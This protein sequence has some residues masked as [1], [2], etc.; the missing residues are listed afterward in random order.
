M[1]HQFRW[2]YYLISRFCF[3]NQNYLSNHIKDIGYEFPKEV[4]TRLLMNANRVTSISET[5]SVRA[6]VSLRKPVL[7]L[8][9]L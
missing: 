2:L 5:F 4:F 6:I 8:D 9:L 1:L 7:L 3:I